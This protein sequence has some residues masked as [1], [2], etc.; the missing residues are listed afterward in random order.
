MDAYVLALNSLFFEKI[1][2]LWLQKFP[3]PLR[4][5]FGYKPLNSLVIWAPKTRGTARFDKIPC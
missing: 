3:V 4:R 5:E 1:S 2:L